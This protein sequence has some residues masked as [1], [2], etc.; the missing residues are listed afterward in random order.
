MIWMTKSRS[1][2]KVGDRFMR[3]RDTDGLPSDYGPRPHHLKGYEG[4]VAKI[5][6][7]RVWDTKGKSHGFLNIEKV[8]MLDKGPFRFRSNRY[9]RHI[10]RKPCLVCGGQAEAHHLTHAQERAKG[11][12]NGDQW[13]VPLCHYHHME[14]HDFAGGEAT[15]WAVN[16]IRPIVWAENEFKQW[17]EE[18]GNTD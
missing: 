11:V 6:R 10:R 8:P 15:F 14:L 2:L 7:L 12:K 5:G 18:N 13:C 1:D 17:S 16:G 9:L 3:T 4:T